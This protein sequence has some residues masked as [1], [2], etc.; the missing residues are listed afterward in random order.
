MTKPKALYIH[1]PF[2]NY[3]CDYCDFT[4]LQYFSFD[5]NPYLDAL[6]VELKNYQ[7]GELDTIYVGGGTPTS[8]TEEELTRL[9]NII[10]PY[11]VNVKEY[12]FEANP[13]SLTLAKLKLLKSH[14]VNR[15]SIGVESTSNEILKAINRHHSYEDVIRLVKEA[16][17]VGFK[18]INVDL[19][20][21]LPHVSKKMI[22]K[23]INNLI[24]LEVEHISC[25]SLTVSPHTA[26]YIKKINA[27]EDDI[28]RDYYDLVTKELESHGYIHY[29]VSNYAKEG[30]FSKHNLTYWRN[31]EYYGLGL[32]ASGY[33]NKVRY[34]NTK[35]LKKYL[36]HQFIDN[37]EEVSK[38]D[39]MNYELMLRLRT[40]EGIDLEEF[41]KRY[42]I[43]L[44]KEK[45]DEISDFVKKNF[46]QISASKITPTYEGMMLLDQIL[47]KLFF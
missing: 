5:V 15:L 12:T 47:V 38:V 27:P 9:L 3:I 22:E 32:G 29:E 42:K 13:D 16:R 26:F 19:I 36:A 18:N 35:N 39:E 11:I 21:G 6:E 33:I 7:I 46:L 4:K 17:S 10:D 24:A 28:L 20:L 40:I 41:K 1:I 37:K 14:H 2:C 25:Y 31:E 45:S 23:D 34:V 44:Y 30:Y 8:L 43:D